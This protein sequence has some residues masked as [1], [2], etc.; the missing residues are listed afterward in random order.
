M[1]QAEDGPAGKEPEPL[2]IFRPNLGSCFITMEVTHTDSRVE[3]EFLPSA[4]GF[5]P[6]VPL[7]QWG[8]WKWQLKNRITTL[9]ELENKLKLTPEER[10]GVILSGNKLAL[11][12]TPHYFNLIERDNPGWDDLYERLNS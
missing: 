11:A 9:E 7:D 3:V 4:P 8:D 2:T 1:G 12:V 10:A 6:G 5:W